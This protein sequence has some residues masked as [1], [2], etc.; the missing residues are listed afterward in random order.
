MRTSF[1]LSALLGAGAIAQPHLRYA[2]PHVHRHRRDEVDTYRQGNVMVEEY[3]EYITVT[4]SPGQDPAA[5]PAPFAVHNGPHQH[6]NE[7]YHYDPSVAPVSVAPAPSVTLVAAPAQVE[8]A[9]VAPTP[10]TSTVASAVETTTPKTQDSTPTTD[11]VSAP[12]TYWSS[13]PLS[14]ITGGSGAVDVLTSANKWRNQWMKAS[15]LPAP[16]QYTW[17]PLIANNSYN[18]AMGPENRATSMVHSLAKGANGQTIA[19]GQCE[20]SGRGN[21]QMNMTEGITG[22]A[23][24]PFEEAWFMWMCEAPND[25]ISDICRDLGNNWQAPIADPGHANIIKGSYTSFGCYYMNATNADGT[26]YVGASE[27]L[28][29]PQDFLGYWTCD[30]AT[31]PSTS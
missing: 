19:S 28:Q 3:V 15:G 27:G 7:E 6:A 20:A 16:A 14:P 2:G 30:F 23:L 10:S 4:G 12:D 5:T 11:T 26:P 8:E 1:A 29:I 24:T 13:S 21:A 9:Y 31:L 22:Q 18:T 17:A 25:A